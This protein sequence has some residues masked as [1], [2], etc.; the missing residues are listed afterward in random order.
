MERA[1]VAGS[2]NVV[3]DL[4]G[5]LEN[6]RHGTVGLLHMKSGSLLE[7]ME[8][9]KGIVFRAGTLSCVRETLDNTAGR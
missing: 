5:S 3:Q 8:L 9:Y 6:S 1:G 2:F 7:L 4:D